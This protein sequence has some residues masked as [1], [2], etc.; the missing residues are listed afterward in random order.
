VLFNDNSA[1][2]QLYYGENKLIF[3]EMLMRSAE[4]DF[5]SASSLKQK[6]ADRH[7]APLG[8]IFL[9]RSQPVFALSP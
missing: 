1:I 8:H 7:V 5:Y 4:L 6:S 2:F 9:I 3:N